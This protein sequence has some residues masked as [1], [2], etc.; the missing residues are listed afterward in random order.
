MRWYTSET[1][2]RY[3]IFRRVRH[4][5]LSVRPHGTTRLPLNGYSRN[6]I[7]ED[8]F[9]N[10]SKKFQVSLKSDKNNRYFTSRHM[11]I[12]DSTLP[13]SSQN[14]KCLRQML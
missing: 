5:C 6:F 4:V 2:T 14:E 7:P 10:L 13:N 1:P 11:C 9:E 8:F 3:G 12:Y